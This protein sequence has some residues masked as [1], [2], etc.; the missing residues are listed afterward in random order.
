MFLLKSTDVSQ[1][2]KQ[3]PGGV[4]LKKVFWKISQY[5]KEN[6]NVGISSL[7]NL[8]T[9]WNSVKKE[10]HHLCSSYNFVKVFWTYFL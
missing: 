6:T 4:L 9:S 2:Q 5:L 8:P 3:P 7:I 1:F 10:T